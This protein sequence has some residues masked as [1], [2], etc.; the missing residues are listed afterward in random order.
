MKL[1]PKCFPNCDFFQQ[2]VTLRRPSTHINSLLHKDSWIAFVRKTSSLLRKWLISCP[3]NLLLFLIGFDVI[4]ISVWLT[5]VTQTACAFGS[6]AQSP[7]FR[8]IP[9]RAY[10][11]TF[12]PR[13]LVPC[14]LATLNRLISYHINWWLGL[15][16]F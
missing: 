13:P 4:L 3:Q 10:A 11:D 15:P 6:C 1:F 8:C 16:T 14:R 2:A 12:L 9:Y 5:I 7:S